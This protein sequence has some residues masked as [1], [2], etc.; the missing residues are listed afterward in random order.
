VVSER[1][2]GGTP[3]SRRYCIPPAAAVVEEVVA[4]IYIYIYS[5]GRCPFKRTGGG[6]HLPLNIT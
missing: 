1:V 2:T 3:T 4:A 6:G 5:G